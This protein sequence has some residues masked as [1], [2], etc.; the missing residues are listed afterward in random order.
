MVNQNSHVIK[1]YPLNINDGLISKE[2]LDV[3][4]A[5]GKV[6]AATAK[7][8]SIFKEADMQE[9][10]S[11]PK[12]YL[13]SIKV[14]EK[15]SILK[16][17]F[18]LDYYQN[19][20]RIEYV[21]LSYKSGKDILYRYRMDGLDTAWQE[22]K[23]M[24]IQYSTLPPGTYT[25]MVDA[26]SLQGHWSG[27]P[28]M[29][30]FTIKPPF[31]QTWWF[32]TLMGLLFLGIVTAISYAI[33]RYYRNRNEVA[34]RLVQLEGQALRAQMNPHFIFNSLNAIHDFI[35]DQDQ[36]SAHLYLSRFAALI[37]RILE[38]S[39]KPQVNLAEEIELLKLYIDLENM[40]FENK[41]DYE[42][43]VDTEDDPIDIFL[44]S[45]LLQPYVENAIRHGLTSKRGKGH[46]KLEIIQKGNKLLCRITD[47]GI[48]RKAANELGGR[49][50]KKHR[51]F[52]MDITKERVEAMNDNGQK[53]K[54]DIAI[55]DLVDAD[56][57]ANGTTVELT[58]PLN[59]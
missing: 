38:L 42:L 49:N 29:A 37:R 35:A 32:R 19:N 8:L 31:W 46:L 27:H 48:G 23:F 16:P 40:R 9:D 10:T 45:M 20:L 14:N 17:Y 4:K 59:H 43:K 5:G 58:I 44:P 33:I 34:R 21:A 13:T 26:R 51:S 52:A 57:N 47:N 36:R 56:G 25:F 1:S 28:A 30:S 22:T 18:N 50:L 53:A 12:V 39:R 54:A 55:I 15:D 11:S 7:G 3:Y 24:N 41:F 6:Y 2:V